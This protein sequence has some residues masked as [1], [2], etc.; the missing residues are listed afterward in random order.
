LHAVTDAASGVLGWRLFLPE[1]SWDD[2]RVP[3]V[4]DGPD[5]DGERAE[6]ARKAAA[7][8]VRRA[9]AKIPEDE[10]YRPKWQMALE[11]IDEAIGWGHRPPVLAADAGYGDTTE[12]RTALSER[13]IP[14]VLAVK[15]TTSAHP[16]H[17]VPITPTATGR[18]GRP[19]GPAYPDEPVSLKTLALQA[20][21]DEPSLLQE[22]TWRHG[23]KT[24]PD[25]RS[26]AMTS[27]SPE[28]DETQ[29][30][31]GHPA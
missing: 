3:A 7:I 23:T 28:P 16:A 4:A 20:I 19:A 5:H 14:Y 12:F 2:D 29:H 30:E 9:R 11:M 17:A 25:N 26:A 6:A 10:R 31:R 15:S 1:A 27:S 21:N 8:R 24:S 18:R 22:T 13:H